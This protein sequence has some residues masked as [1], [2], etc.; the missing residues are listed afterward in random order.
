MATNRPVDAPCA[1]TA[2]NQRLSRLTEPTLVER[3]PLQLRII[4]WGSV[5]VSR[6]SISINRIGRVI[7]KSVLG[8]LQ[9]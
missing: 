2:D 1:C 9:K 6:R 7:R 8:P 4:G 3:N 5:E